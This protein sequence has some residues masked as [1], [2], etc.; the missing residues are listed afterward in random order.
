MLAR[1]PGLVCG[2]DAL[3]RSPVS[4]S[5]RAVALHGHVQVELLPR[6]VSSPVAFPAFRHSAVLAGQGQDD[7]KHV[8]WMHAHTPSLSSCPL[9]ESG[10]GRTWRRSGCPT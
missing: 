3:A 1:D 4:V 6:V 5:G 9:F 8:G 10:T 2:T 7:G